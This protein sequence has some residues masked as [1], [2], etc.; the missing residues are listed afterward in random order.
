MFFATF[1]RL[2]Q[3]DFDAW[4]YHIHWPQNEIL[5]PLTG[6]VNFVVEDIKFA[7]NAW[8]LLRLAMFFGVKHPKVLSNMTK[9]TPSMDI[10]RSANRLFFMHS[11]VNANL[12]K[13]KVKIALTPTHP[14][15]FPVQ[16]LAWNKHRHFSGR[17][18]AGVELVLGMEN[19]LSQKV[20]E[21]CDLCMYIPQYGSIGS[22]SMISA[23]AIAA[24]STWREAVQEES[25][26]SHISIAPQRAS[27][28]HKPLSNSP[29]R[30]QHSLPHEM[31]LL[32]FSNAAIKAILKE[33]R[34]SYD[35]QLSV[36][37]YNELGDRNIGAVIRNANVFNCEYVAVVNRRRF[38]RR[39]AL[40]TQKVLDVHFFA[41]VDEDAAR[42]LFEGYEVW[43]LYPYYPNLLIYEAGRKEDAAYNLLTFL[44]HED[45][46][47]QAWGATQHQLT[48]EHPLVVRYPHLCQ[49][50]VF[51]DD[52]RSLAS[53]VQD[54]K[55]RKL[56]GILLAVPEEGCSPH[57]CL[58]KLSHRVVYVT[59]PSH[60]PHQT[61]R[62][63]NPA[64]STAI[65]LE[66]LRCATEGL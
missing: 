59:S 50:V 44:R 9:T 21:E 14:C 12:N 7:S 15:A 24:H 32:G 56:R 42:G 49:Q 66:R 29:H 45:P 10:M 5:S 31:D 65:A 23:L 8:S 52:D 40:G 35:L 38:N 48:S 2:T 13:T 60:L 39:G 57:P 11:R 27:H 18:S 36:L 62:G 46:V 33:R 20:V 28:G 53:C 19:G 6:K 16:E 30:V 17:Q 25:N 22:L 43:L 58:C 41:T 64:L 34:Q 63:L 3:K 61:Q 26:T 1:K 54:V 55:R 37:M 47:L 51:L 4:G